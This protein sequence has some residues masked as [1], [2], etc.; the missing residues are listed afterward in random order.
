MNFWYRMFFLQSDA[1]AILKL[2]VNQDQEDR[3]AWHYDKKGLFSVK[4]AY[5][6][7]VQIRENEYGRNATTSV[8][9][10]IQ[11]TTFG[12][13]KIWNMDV[14]NKLKMFMWRLVHMHYK[15]FVDL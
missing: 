6:L 12:W 1:E 14:P 10:D 15:K 13:R 4:S 9:T 11:G 8:S 3:P 2:K 7:A 5:K